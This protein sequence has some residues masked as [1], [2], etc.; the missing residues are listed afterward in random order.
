MTICWIILKTDC[1]ILPPLRPHLPFFRPR[2]NSSSVLSPSG[3]V[4]HSQV[5]EDSSRHLLLSCQN[6]FLNKLAWLMIGTSRCKRSVQIPTSRIS[7]K[8]TSRIS[9][10]G[11][12]NMSNPNLSI[13][14]PFWVPSIQ[15]LDSYSKPQTFIR[16]V[17]Q[18]LSFFV[19]KHTQQPFT[20]N[21]CVGRLCDAL[22]LRG[23]SRK[24]ICQSPRT[25]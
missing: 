14:H 2:H 3:M 19:L 7:W 15:F 8:P 18:T 17:T 20:N 24:P 22:T 11:K 23:I 25:T 10:K 12:K 13:C 1:H 16:R 4:R 6:I 5:E 21:S 9:W